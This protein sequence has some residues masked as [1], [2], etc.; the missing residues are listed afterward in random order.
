MFIDTSNFLAGSREAYD[1]TT[2][3]YTATED[4]FFTY[5]IYGY[6][7]NDKFLY[8]DDV[9]ITASGKDGMTGLYSLFW[10]G[11]LKKGQ[12]IKWDGGGR[13]SAFGL[14]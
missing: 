5:G 6:I 14:K 7:N 4:C 8:I 13:W 3:S 2:T 9:L 10:C 12:T 11:F 1:E